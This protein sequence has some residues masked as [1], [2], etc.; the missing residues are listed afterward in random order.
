MTEHFAFEMPVSLP[1]NIIVTN[2]LQAG[3]AKEVWQGN[4]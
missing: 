2:H 1:K 3:E 4:L